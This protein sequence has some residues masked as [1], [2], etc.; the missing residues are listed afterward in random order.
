MDKQ[1]RYHEK[2]VYDLPVECS[3]VRLWDAE[4]AINKAMI[5]AAFRPLLKSGFV[6]PYVALMPDYHPGEGS[7][8]GSVIPT[9]DVLLPSVIGGDLGCGMTAIALPLEADR[10]ATELSRLEG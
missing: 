4:G 8:I 9:R 6:W 3:I 5:E 10:L 1:F 2:H 7:M